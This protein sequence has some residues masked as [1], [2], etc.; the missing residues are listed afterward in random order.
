MQTI[1]SNIIKAT[2]KWRRKQIAWRRHFHQHPELSF[3][4][5]KTT[6]YLRRAVSSM[7]L[8]ILPLK[9]KTGLLAEVRG[10]RPG[11]TIALRS[12]I[13]ALPVTERTG[14]SFGSKVDGCMHACGHDVHMASLLGAAAVLSEMR[15]DLPGTVRFIF[16]PAEEMPPGGAA[17]MIENGALD[18]VS[19]IFG[20]HVDPTVATGKI[21]LRDGVTMAA[22]NDFDLIVHGRGGHG[23]RPHETVDA[24]VVAAEIVQALQ[25]IASRKIDPI[26]PVAITIGRIEGG[27]ARNVITDRVT[28]NGTARAL[29]EQAA[30]ELPK[31]VKRIAQSIGRA[32]G[33]KVEVNITHGYPVFK[34]HPV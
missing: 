13:D 14:L 15:D 34:N 27:V 31:L 21:G 32:H 9:M 24:V 26:A 23:A 28:L 6:A 7:G 5:H 10:K 18:S 30:R 16:Q 1:H 33:A 4:E 12:D 17:P 11:R 3:A 8:K 22:V 20:L 2:R 25:T 29:S 19:M